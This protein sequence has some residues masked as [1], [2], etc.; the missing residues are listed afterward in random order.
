MKKIV[1][2]AT[3]LV[4]FASC[5]STKK[6]EVAVAVDTTAVA[7]VTATPALE[8]VTDTLLKAVEVTPTVTGTVKAK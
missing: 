6:E 2:I 4:L 7:P 8:V 5:G 3:A 1:L